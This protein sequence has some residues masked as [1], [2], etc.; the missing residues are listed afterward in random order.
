VLGTGRGASVLARVAGR[1]I[2]ACRALR[3]C[4]NDRLIAAIEARVI[5]RQV[6]RR[7][8]GK[9]AAGLMHDGAVGGSE[10]GASQGRSGDR[11]HTRE[12]GSAA[13]GAPDLPPTMDRACADVS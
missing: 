9:F 8:G 12:P 11:S 3:R 13:P 1:K 6:P 10:I 7:L 4:R 2:A 5:D